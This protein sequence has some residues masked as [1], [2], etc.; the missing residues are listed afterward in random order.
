MENLRKFLLKIWQLCCSLFAKILDIIH[1][2]FF[3]C[4]KFTPKKNTDQEISLFFSIFDIM[5]EVYI[6]LLHTLNV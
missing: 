5:L 3:L 4:V 2:G 6:H 1:T